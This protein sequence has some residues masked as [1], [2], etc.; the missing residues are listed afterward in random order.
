MCD[1]SRANG[2]SK[3]LRLLFTDLKGL[4]TSPK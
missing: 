4:G 2:A 1:L 3:N